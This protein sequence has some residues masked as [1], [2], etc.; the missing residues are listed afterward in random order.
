MGKE[1]EPRWSVRVK[2][3]IYQVH[4]SP[5]TDVFVGTDG[6]GGRLLAFDAA[7]GRETL[8]LKPALGGVG[9]LSKVPGHDVLVAT[10]SVSKSYSVPPRLLVLSMKDRRHR[11]DTDCCGLIGTWDHGA[12]GPAGKQWTRLA[13]LDVREGTAIL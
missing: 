9:S 12:V 5:E 10:Y 8:N 3:Y 1:N 4:R 7:T 11:L 13:I 6:N 2:P